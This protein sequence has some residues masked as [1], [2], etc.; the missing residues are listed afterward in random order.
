MTLATPP[1]PLPGKH[2]D[3]DEIK[4][5][6]ILLDILGIGLSVHAADATPLWR[7]ATAEKLLHDPALAWENEKNESLSDDE[8]PLCSVL[9]TTQPVLERIVAV[10]DNEGHVT[11]LNTNALPILDDRGTIRRALL[12]L[13]EITEQKF[14]ESRLE[15]LSVHDSLTGVFNE[16]QVMRLLE[17]E[18]QRGRRYGTPF[19]LAQIDVDHF[20]EL[21]ATRGQSVADGILAA[22][23]YLLSKALR[24]TDIVGRIGTD[25]FLL[26]LPNTHL[27]DALGALERLRALIE[28]EILAKTGERITISGGITE[29]TGE[30]G[31]ALVERSTA[32]LVHARDTGRNRFCIDDGAI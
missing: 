7:N 3:D 2:A 5:Y 31:A 1:E 9:R 28:T 32:L 20:H 13:A 27:T 12:V 24:E 10:R 23:G 18:V 19:T 8:M 30:H 6:G 26:I 15:R 14:L 4:R 22:L 17:S 11:W 25:E 16:R 21:A 29:F